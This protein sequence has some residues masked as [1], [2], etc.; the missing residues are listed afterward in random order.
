[1]SV[2][3]PKFTFSLNEIN[4][5]GFAL[6]IEGSSSDVGA[7]NP[8]FR[9]VLAEDGG[10]RAWLYPMTR[11]S[12]GDVTVAIPPEKFFLENKSYQGQVEVVLGNHYF[13]PAIVD[14]EFAKPLKVEA[15]VK[16]KPD[17]KPNSESKLAEDIKNSIKV[18]SVTAKNKTKEETNKPIILQPQTKKGKKAWNDLSEL[19]QKKLMQVLRERKMNELR[20]A[21]ENDKN[22]EELQEKA[23]KSE[24]TIKDQL[25]F[26][27]SNSLSDEE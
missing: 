7:T 21:K 24:S 11:D 25:K 14:I 5:L 8:V 22:R 27:L 10:E 16:V 15:V 17:T 18:S 2:N 26:L 23:H 12:E 9:F 19:E 3:K 4:T 13:V 1:M 6:T 20:K